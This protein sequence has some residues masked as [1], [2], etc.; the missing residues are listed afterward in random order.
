MSNGWKLWNTLVI[1]IMVSLCLYEKVCFFFI[2]YDA[3][4]TII[5]IYFS[6][7]IHHK[8]SFYSCCRTLFN[9]SYI[10]L[11]FRP[12]YSSK[13]DFFHFLP[14][15][16]GPKAIKIVLDD[17]LLGENVSKVFSGRTKYNRFAFMIALCK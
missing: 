16:K 10:F 3:I 14:L 2:K 13:V 6:I 15:A 5:C 4:V 7:K 17:S 1:F 9:F 11:P 12:L 8:S